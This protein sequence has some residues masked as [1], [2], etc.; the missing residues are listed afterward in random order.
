MLTNVGELGGFQDNQT[1]S[2]GLVLGFIT[3]EVW[4]GSSQPPVGCW[5]S[6]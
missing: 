3:Y 1:Q 6:R 4:K 2:Q 5:W